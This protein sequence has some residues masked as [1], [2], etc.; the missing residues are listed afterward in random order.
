MSAN[1]VNMATKGAI[2]HSFDKKSLSYAKNCSLQNEVAKILLDFCESW[3][4]KK[5]IDLGAGSGNV[6][7]NLVHSVDFLLGIDNAPNMLAL[8]PRKLPHIAQIRLIVGDFESYDFSDD[9]DLILS[10]SSLQWAKNLDLLFKRLKDS[11]ESSH[12]KFAFAI[13]TSESLRELHAFLGTASPLKSSSE[14]LAIAQKYFCIESKI[15]HFKREFSTR[16]EL[17]AYLKNSALL[18]GGNL[19]FRDKKRLKCAF[20]HTALNFEVLFIKN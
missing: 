20:P 2:R 1:N 9:F 19:A 12:K 15:Q 7:L 4:Y 5:I 18:G 17:L 3:H 16:D 11:I 8:H 6:A 10:S 13:F 14:I